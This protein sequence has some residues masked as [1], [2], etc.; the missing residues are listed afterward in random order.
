MLPR[1]LSSRKVPGLTEVMGN[2]K[3]DMHVSMPVLM[4]KVMPTGLVSLLGLMDAASITNFVRPDFGCI[5][6]VGLG[7]QLHAA[8][9]MVG[10]RGHPRF[11][12]CRSTPREWQAVSARLDCRVAGHRLGYQVFKRPDWGSQRSWSLG[13]WMASL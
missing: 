7:L 11:P 2:T 12:L 3:R 6:L 13:V 8:Q 4:Q 10:S 5:D 1:F 9:K